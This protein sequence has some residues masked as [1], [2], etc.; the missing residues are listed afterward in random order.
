MSRDFPSCILSPISEF[1]AVV[2]ELELLQDFQ[3]LHVVEKTE[4]F[5]VK[6]SFNL[7]L[8]QLPGAAIYQIKGGEANESK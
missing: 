8:A 6:S 1:S 4:E 2:T 3:W 5:S 7:E